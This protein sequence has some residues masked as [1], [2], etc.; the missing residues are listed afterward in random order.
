[1]KKGLSIIGISAGASAAITKDDILFIL[2]LVVTIINA[3]IFYLEHKK[4]TTESENH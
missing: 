2:G 3:V 4:S 1:M